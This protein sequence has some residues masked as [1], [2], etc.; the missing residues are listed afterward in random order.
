MNQKLLDE[1]V[2]ILV[3]R[4]V[5]QKLKVKAILKGMTRQDYLEKIANETKK[6]L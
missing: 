5:A 4:D 6:T 2:P 3:K 1:L